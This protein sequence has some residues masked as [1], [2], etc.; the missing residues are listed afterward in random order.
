MEKKFEN[1]KSELFQGGG[2]GQALMLLELL[3]CD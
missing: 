2:Y 3:I 1:I